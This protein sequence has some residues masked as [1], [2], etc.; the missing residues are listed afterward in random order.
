MRVKVCVG[1]YEK[2]VLAN[3]TWDALRVH[4]PK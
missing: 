3:T 2:S 1:L 4:V